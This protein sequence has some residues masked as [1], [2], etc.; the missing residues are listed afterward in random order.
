MS[1]VA[2]GRSWVIVTG[3][4]LNHNYVNAYIEQPAGESPPH[5][6]QREWCNSRLTCSCCGV[7]GDLCDHVAHHQILALY[8][9]V[10]EWARDT[11]VYHKP[12]T[13]NCM[14]PSQC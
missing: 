8:D 2:G 7:Y 5:R 13:E 11:A 3:E 14:C 10:E 6:T 9:T 12:V 1:V 4:V